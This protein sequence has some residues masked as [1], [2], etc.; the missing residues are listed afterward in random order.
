MERS[1]ISMIA[2]AW[3]R[4]DEWRQIKRLCP[5]LQATYAGWLANAE[6]GIEALGSPL[7]EQAVK[8]ILTVDELRKWKRSTGSK[9]DARARA[10]LAV[11]IAHKIHGT[12]H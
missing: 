5:D 6:A 11:R 7:K 12:H 9:V 10:E 8:V 3:F 2:V 1:N 4:L